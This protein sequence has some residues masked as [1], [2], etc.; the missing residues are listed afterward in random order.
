MLFSIV[1]APTDI[2]FLHTLSSIYCLHFF[3]FLLF[4]ATLAACGSFQARGQIRATAAT[5]HHSHSHAGSGSICNLHHT[6][7]QCWI[8]DPLSE[9]RD[10]AQIHMDTSWIG[11]RCVTTG[12]PC[13]YF[14]MMAIPTSV[15]WYLTEVLICI[16]LIISNVKPLFMCLLAIC[17][18][19]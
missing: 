13:L 14:L 17:M 7:W 4:K 8:P 18:S 19:L 15:R 3:F 11:F 12:T 6:L 16:S 9:A 2:P 1:V 10:Q 5:L